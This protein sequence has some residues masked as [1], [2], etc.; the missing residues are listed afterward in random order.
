VKLAPVILRKVPIG[1]IVGM[2]VIPVG[3]AGVLTENAALRG[4]PS[5]SSTTT[6][7]APSAALHGTVAVIDVAELRENVVAGCPPIVTLQTVT[8]TARKLVPVPV[9]VIV[10]PGKPDAG[11]LILPARAEA[12]SAVSAR[13]NPSAAAN[14]VTRT[15]VLPTGN[16][17]G[18]SS[19]LVEDLVA[20]RSRPVFCHRRIV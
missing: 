12:G 3:A 18:G 1:P 5:P 4:A 20:A 14:A 2:N 8:G 17:I 10:L 16:L 9:M 19:L 6:L 7:P 13:T 11:T 15:N